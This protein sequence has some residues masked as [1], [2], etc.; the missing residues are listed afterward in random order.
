MDELKLNLTSKFM[1][2]IVTKVIAYIIKTKL[3]YNIDVQLNEITVNATDGKIR[4]HADIGAETSNE[5]L[6]KIIKSIGIDGA[7]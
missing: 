3:G 6:L 2:G 5:E 7:L 4:V 1:K